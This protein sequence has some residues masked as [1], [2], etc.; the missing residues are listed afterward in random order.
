MTTR[1]VLRLL[2]QDKLGLAGIAIL[3]FFILVAILAPQ[4]IPYDPMEEHYRS[5]GSFA[6]MD[7]P[8]KEHW[9][10]TNR[11]GRDIFS[12]VI[13]GTR[14]ALFVGIVS[15][16][17][18]TVVGTTIGLVAGY[19]GGWIDDLLMRF[20]DIV[21]GIP[22]LPF[23]MIMVAVLGPSIWN[24]IIAIVLIS[25]RTTARVIRSEVL[26]LKERTF[27]QAAKLTGASHARI[28]F[29]HL[30][31]NVIPLSLVFSSLAM[32]WAIITE[33]SVSFLGYGD[34]L[35]ISWGKILFD[36]YVAQAINEAWWWVV[37]PGLAITLLVMSGFFVSRS[38]E[39][40]LNPRLRKL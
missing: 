10:G 22:F 16:I 8:S 9:F 21:Y 29:R 14:V 20:T 6:R 13:A 32:G 40:I 25:W 1:E 37:P 7:P 30:A 27:I 2:M 19:F 5:D 36:A 28:I 11:M 35:L 24:I 26:T 3:L 4:I 12:Q 18:V 39:Q 23:A 17:M 15:G 38:L 34:P 31:P 33:A